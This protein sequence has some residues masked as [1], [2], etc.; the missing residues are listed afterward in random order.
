MKYISVDRLFEF[1][2]HDAEMVLDKFD[3]HQLTVIVRYLNI[4]KDAEQNPFETDMEIES[5]RITF[6]GFDIISYEPGRTWQK[7]EEGSLYS[8]EPQVILSGD[9]AHYCFLEQ[10]KTRITIYYF[11]INEGKT[12][13]IDA[14]AKDPFFTV[15]VAFDRATVEWD[16]YKQEAWYTLWKR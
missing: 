13:F 11:D 9:D 10:L 2:F 1:E 14:M 3:D 6:E 8:D 7:D 5:A 12:Y 16:N 15:C 4:H